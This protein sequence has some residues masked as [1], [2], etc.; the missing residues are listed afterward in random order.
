MALSPELVICDDPVSALDPPGRSA[1]IDLFVKFQRSTDVAYVFITRGR[2]VAQ[3]GS[4]RMAVLEHG[5]V[6]ARIDGA[7]ATVSRPGCPRWPF[8]AMP[9]MD[10]TTPAPCPAGRPRLSRDGAI[11]RAWSR[12]A[13]QR[14]W[15][16]P[17]DRPTCHRPRSR[18]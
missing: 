10:P 15:P 2:A 18:G 14:S 8:P 9:G 13:S 6:V 7:R 16:R 3:R 5:E 12:A 4:H 17:G 1:V 11:P